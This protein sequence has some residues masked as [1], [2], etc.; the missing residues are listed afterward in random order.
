MGDAA[1]I[2]PRVPST[3]SSRSVG[4]WEDMILP[5]RE[6]P[7]NCADPRNPG[8]SK[9]D[10]KLGKIVCEISL[11]D[12]RRWK[13]DD[14]YL[15]RGLPNIYSPSLC[16]PL[17]PL[18]LRTTAIAPWWWTRSSVFELN[19]ET[20]I[21]WTQRC[22]WKPWLSVFGYAPGDWD[23]VN[24]EMH[25]EARIE[26][27]WRWT[28]RPWS[29]ELAGHNR[30]GLEIHWEAVIERVWRYTWRP[31]PSWTQR[32]SGRP[33]SSEFEDALGGHD[34]AN[35]QA[36]I[37]RV[38]RYTWRRW[39]SEFGHALAGYNRAR[40]EEYLEEVDLEGGATAAETLFIG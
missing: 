11:N 6:N 34:R 10:Q 27:V 40:L 31:R 22:T 20:W 14:V 23:R 33:R 3:L 37:E 5:G 35:L 29:C 26:R 24:S 21:V 30:A 7:C 38:W 8:Q 13:W 32:C 36:V 18:Y 15:L 12:K 19:L 1:K 4:R 39:S 28:W 25:L 9:W 16:P 17:W 2:S